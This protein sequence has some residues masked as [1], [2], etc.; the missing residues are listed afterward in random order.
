MSAGG[1]WSDCWRRKWTADVA[2]QGDLR[3]LDFVATSFSRAGGKRVSKRMAVYLFLIAVGAG[4]HFAV[5]LRLFNVLN[6]LTIF[7]PVPP[8]EKLAFMVFSLPIGALAGLISRPS[9][10]VIVALAIVNSLVLSFVGAT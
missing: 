3:R 1:L 10:W 8:R 5:W 4:F 2:D 9:D 7:D 6:E